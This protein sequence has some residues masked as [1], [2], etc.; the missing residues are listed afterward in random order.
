MSVNLIYKHQQKTYELM[1]KA[2]RENGRAAYVFP[3]GC[4]KSFPVLKYIEENPDKKVLYVSPSIEIIN[5]IKKYISRYIL[6][7]KKVSKITMPNFRAITYQKIALAEDIV[8]MHP[9]VIVF[10]EIHRMGAEKWEQGID[11]LIEANPSAEIIGMSATP[12]RTDKRN[13]AYEKFGDDVVYEMSLTDAL[14]GRKEGEVVLKGA[15]YVRALSELKTYA[16]DLRE[17]IELTED[18]NRKARLIEKFQRLNAIIS[19]A[20]GLSDLMEQSITKKNGKYIVFCTDRNEMFEK[21]AQANEIFGKVN[22]NI[23]VDYVISG[24]DNSG[25]TQKE[26]RKTIEEFEDRENG[27]SLNLL[28]CVDMLNEGRH[29]E[30]IDGEIQFRPTESSILYK[31]QIGRVLSADKSAEE[32][33]IID[34]V[35]NWLRQIDTFNE[36]GKAIE[37]NGEKNSYDLF[38]FSIDEIEL[39]SL[40]KEIGEEL[41]YNSKQT[42]NEIINWLESHD[43]KMP[44]STIRKDG[45]HFGVGE[46]TQ[47]EQ[48]EVNLYARWRVSADRRALEACRRNRNR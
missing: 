4:G 30:G 13:M 18:E 35:N 36:I 2:L 33:V 1:Q 11:S 31:Q 45:K 32:T 48:D 14:S 44:R 37:S 22:P 8:N 7:G 21:M 6:D 27:D 38:K 46:M 5:Q 42:Y 17:G 20:P 26:N 41:K 47:E 16:N 24:D 10:D 23:K 12:E 25:K 43:G 40:L 29:I 9:D 28:F 15:R 34:A 19:S 39:V 3:V